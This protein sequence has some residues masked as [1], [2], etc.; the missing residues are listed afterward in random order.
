MRAPALSGCPADWR[1]PP[2]STIQR[3]SCWPACAPLHCCPGRDRREGA[4]PVRVPCVLGCS[5]AG[6]AQGVH[7]RARLRDGS[8]NGTPGWLGPLRA[9]L[10]I[11]AQGTTSRSV[12]L[13]PTPDSARTARGL[14]GIRSLLLS[15]PLPPP[16][17]KHFLKKEEM[18]GRSQG[19]RRGG[20]A[21]VLDGVGLLS[22]PPGEQEPE[23]FVL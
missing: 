18:A 17:T 15:R 4:T 3:S 2:R 21:K 11:S 14:L 16:Q 13:N 1:S 8:Q 6:L 10:L 19:S 7:W 23:P 20:E 22:G 12:G 5:L 9:R